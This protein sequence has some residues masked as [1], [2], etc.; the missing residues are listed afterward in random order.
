[1]SP[2]TA[3]LYKYTPSS[4]GISFSLTMEPQIG[5]ETSELIQFTT[6]LVAR[7]NIIYYQHQ[8]KFKAHF[9]LLYGEDIY[10]SIC[11]FDKLRKKK[12]RMLSTLAFLLRCRDKDTIPRFAVLRYPIRTAATQ[13]ILHRTSFALVRER[14]QYTRRLLSNLDRDLLEV[15]LKLSLKLSPLDWEWI[16]QSTSARACSVMDK[17]SAQQ[18]KKFH[19]LQE[20]QHCNPPPPLEKERTV[21]NLTGKELDEACT[22]VLAKGLNFAP[23]PTSTPTLQVISGVERAITG[24]PVDAAEEVRS[25]VSRVLKR[26]TTSRPNITKEE[27]AALRKMRNDDSIVVLPADKGNAS[28]VMLSTDYKQKIQAIL[29][30]EAYRPLN[31]DPTTSVERKTTNL[32]NRS[33]L[34]KDTKKKLISY[35]S[36]PPRMYGVPKIHKAEVPLRPII[37]TIGGPTY[38]LA[39]FLT[40]QL[41]PLVGKCPHHISN[42]SEFVKILRNITVAPSDLLVSFDVVSLFTR[43]PVNDAMN[44]LQPHFQPDIINLFRHAL[45]S[46]YFLYDG[47]FY[48]QTDGI[49]MGSPLSPAIANFYMEHFEQAALETAIHKP[50]HFFR[51]VD[52]TFVVWPHGKETLQEF[53][54]H[55]NGINSNIQFTMEV[56][57]NGQLPFLDILISKKTDGTLGHAVYRKKTHTDLYLYGTSHHH[58]SQ[59]RGVLNT[60]FHRAFA[61]SDCNNLP[62]ELDHLKRIFLQNGYKN[63]EIRLALK[64]TASPRPAMEDEK[65]P[66][67]SR[68]VAC[69]PY[70]GATSGKIS[71]ILRKFDIKTI[72][73]PPPKIKQLIRPVKDN[74]GLK[75]AGVYR[76]PC[77]CGKQY[78]GHTG[79]TVEVRCKE[80][81]RNIRLFYP[82]KSAVAEHAINMG[83]RIKFGETAILARSSNFWERVVREAVEIRL[84]PNNMNRDSGIQLSPAWFHAID[85]LRSIRANRTPSIE[86]PE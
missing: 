81:A 58:P 61:I 15:H 12:A 6:W 1:M 63:N 29:E 34:P 30:D 38:A 64:R 25:E 48:E 23:T 80:H 42:S 32:I 57:K 9:T 53:L 39:K 60:L 50:T 46:T 65:P 20:K 37:N 47:R 82:D 72:H 16:D 41:Q 22:A 68:R 17:T 11:S 55:L 36:V 79:R 3:V 8:E 2:V 40:G 33:G 7:E 18:S 14:I 73:L 51:Y 76:I 31:R 85:S 27:R 52:D 28:V 26:T 19:S 83:H 84:E 70:M 4:P 77:E 49:A 67:G 86:P 54:Q 13:R 35:G 56:E 59:R 24:L 78:I 62:E 21:V 44:L 5:F 66:D 45:S 10:R 69:I 74:L 75:T 43:V 71:R